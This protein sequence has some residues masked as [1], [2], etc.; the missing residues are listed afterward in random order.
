VGTVFHHNKY[1]H[2]EL[3]KVRRD[4]EVFYYYDRE[5]GDD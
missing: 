1:I 5:E 4:N 3:K 2:R